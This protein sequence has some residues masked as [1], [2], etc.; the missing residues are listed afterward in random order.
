LIM[1]FLDASDVTSEEDLRGN[2]RTKPGR[3]HV[4]VLQAEEKGSKK[5][6]SP[7]IECEFQVLCE[8]ID[9]NGKPTVGQRNSTIRMFL[10]LTGS[11]DEKTKTCLRNALL[12]ALATGIMKPGE[13]KEPDWSEAIGRELVINVKPNTFKANDGTDIA[14]SEVAMFGY[15]SLGNEQ[16]T[17]VPK[18]PT[19]PGMQQLAKSG[20]LKQPAAGS[21]GNGNGAK[22]AATQPTTQAAATTAAT[23]SR[24][25]F[26]DL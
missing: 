26:S 1:A 21:N 19:T 7:G 14:S 15:W 16:V 13:K 24:S 20:G 8:G 23:T 25:K 9:A 6:G 12:L 22:A 4:C 10:N 18:D 17:D 2:A 11:D 5:K 3:Y